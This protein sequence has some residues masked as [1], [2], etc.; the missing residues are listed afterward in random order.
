MTVVL[1]TG[2]EGNEV[3]RVESIS[4]TLPEIMVYLT[5]VQNQYESVYGAQIWEVDFEGMTLEN[6]VKET[7]LAQIAQIKTM[8]LLGEKYGL[9]LSDEEKE[10]AAQAAGS[11]FGSLNQA[12]RDSMVVTEEDIT[13]LYAEYALAD[14]VYQYIIKDINP[15]ISDDEARNITVQQIMLK[16]YA[17]DGTGEMIAYTENIKREAYERILDIRSRIEAGEDFE[18][19]ITLY[20]EDEQSVYS[21]GKGEMEEPFEA[22]AFMLET[23]EVSEIVETSYGYHIIKC[24]NTFNREETDVNKVR[25]VEERREAVF[26]QEYN[27]F[28]GTLTKYLNEVLWE[29]V[30][31]IHNR[32]V[33]TMDFFDVYREFFSP[34]N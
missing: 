21:F 13:K 24:I 1:T 11:Y 22:A 31:F 5:T 8:N 28:V 17:L 12:E 15:E 10:R 14:K 33:T 25:I 30:G 18:K 6:N 32:E 19:L 23:G 20:N 3:F 7:V 29:Q 9:E 34:G 26:E 2:F 4:C 16:T 27:A